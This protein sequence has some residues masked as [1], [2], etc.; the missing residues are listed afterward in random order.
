MRPS[1]AK[2][3]RTPLAAVLLLPLLEGCGLSTTDPVVCTLEVRPG[4][5][6]EVRDGFTGDPLADSAT[7]T[8]RDGTYVETVK[9]SFDGLTLAGAHERAGTYDVRVDRS[10]YVPWRTAGVEVA[11]GICHVETVEL[12]APMVRIGGR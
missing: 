2:R 4:I 9:E 3:P 11:A 8:L 7:L 10:G 12:Q 1:P 5:V 6:V